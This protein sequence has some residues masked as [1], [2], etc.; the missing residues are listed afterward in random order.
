MKTSAAVAFVVTLREIVILSEETY[1]RTNLG[2]DAPKPKVVVSC[3][4][5]LR[6]RSTRVLCIPILVCSFQPFQ[7]KF[8]SFSILTLNPSLVNES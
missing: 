3:V 2:P 8:Y 5:I 7:S 6:V 4:E 1:C